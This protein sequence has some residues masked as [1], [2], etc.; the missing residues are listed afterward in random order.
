VSGSTF[1][2]TDT[3]VVNGLTYYYRISAVNSV[4]EGPLSGE[5]PATPSQGGASLP[6][7]ITDLKLTKDGDEITLSWTTPNDG[8]SAIQGYKIYRSTSSSSAFYLATIS[9]ANSY[10]E[11]L[12]TEDTYYYWVVA[13]NEIGDGPMPNSAVSSEVSGSAGMGDLTF[14]IIII[15]VL[16]VGVVLVLYLVM[17]RGKAIKPS[18][19]QTRQGPAQARCPSCGA[20]LTGGP[21]CGNCGRKM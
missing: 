13:F 8:G 4:G 7:Q 15:V 1:V 12:P 21:F 11:T 20:P 14:I 6:G 16:V 3:E 10:S 19:G 5:Q 2:W 9:P 18:S 17:R